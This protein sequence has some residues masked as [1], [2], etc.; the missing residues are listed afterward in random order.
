MKFIDWMFS[1]PKQE[2]K[3]VVVMPKRVSWEE[4]RDAYNKTHGLG[5]TVI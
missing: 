5:N 4:S 2:K 3:V 1:K